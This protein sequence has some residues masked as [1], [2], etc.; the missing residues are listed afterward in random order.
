MYMWSNMIKTGESG[1]NI[2]FRRKDLYVLLGLL[3][4]GGLLT[5]GILLFSRPG[6]MVVVRVGGQPVRTLPLSEETELWIEGKDGGTNRLIIR[7]GEAWVAEASCPDGLCMGMGHIHREGQSIICLPNEVVIEIS[8]DG[9]ENEVDM[10]T[11][12]NRP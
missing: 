11:G 9:D 5:A 3:L 2:R 4:A 10:V 8:N 7:G 6:K 12:R 1:R